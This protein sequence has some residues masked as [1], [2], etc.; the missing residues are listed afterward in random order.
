[1]DIFARYS[2]AEM[3]P[4]N[5]LLADYLAERLAPGEFFQQIPWDDCAPACPPRRVPEPEA[6]SAAL[7]AYQERIGADKTALENARRLADPAVQVVTVG[8]QPGLLTGPLY[9]PFK[10]VTAIALARRLGKL[11]DRP[12]VPVF[13]VGCDD[14]DRAEVDHCGCWD[15]RGLMHPIRYPENAG[16]PGQIVG[17]LPVREY[18]GE[19]LAQLDPLLAGLPHADGTLALAAETAELSADFGEWFSRLLARL[20]GPLG[21]VVC[22]PRLP[23]VRRLGAEVP[24]RELAEPLRTTKLVNDAARKLHDAGYQPVLTRPDDALNLFLFDGLRRH[25]VTWNGERFL[26][27][28]REYTREELLALLDADPGS[29]LPNAV[30]RP[31]MQE[32]LFG[33]AAFVAGPNELCYWAELPAVFR[34]LGVDMPPVIPRA[35]A[36]LLTAHAAEFLRAS[37]IDPLRLLLAPDEVRL[38]LLAEAQPPALKQVFERARE[39]VQRLVA[40]LT[41]TLS[42]YE[43]TLAG[44]ALATHQRMLNEI[45]RLERKTLKAVERHS[46]GLAERFAR[47]AI[48]LFPDHGLQERLLNICSLLARFG[49]EWPAQLLDLLD[50]QEGYHLFVEI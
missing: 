33:S 46:T 5:R 23:A 24:R 42:G 26:A 13:W 21:L 45:E 38:G 4:G 41:E 18:A 1:M 28:E 37:G 39:E 14:D 48:Q 3:D 15:Q 8:Q 17:G 40:A 35:G 50:G 31:V 19:I 25:R 20:F 43:P 27:G 9:T 47:T 30:L 6:L 22:D 2:L 7:A 12:A 36:T 49:P 29:L 16:E 32:Y 11:L 44:S 10:A 34:A